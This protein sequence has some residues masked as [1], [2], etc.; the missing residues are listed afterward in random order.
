MTQP[1]QIGTGYTQYNNIKV[2][3]M[4][5]DKIPTSIQKQPNK[6]V[7]KVSILIEHV[8]EK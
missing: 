4:V 8:K 1:V 3:S 2:T 5:K 7:E 6:C